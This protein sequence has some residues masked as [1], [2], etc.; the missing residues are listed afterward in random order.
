[1]R[2]A[3]LISFLLVSTIHIPG[4]EEYY[5]CSVLADPGDDEVM[6]QYAKYVL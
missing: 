1:M 2:L 6:S 3:L 5:S 4:A